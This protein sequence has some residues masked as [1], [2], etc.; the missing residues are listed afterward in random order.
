MRKLLCSLG[1][2][3]LLVWASGTLADEAAATNG[4]SATVQ[5]AASALL[6]PP[7][8]ATK[9]TPAAAQ[10]NTPLPRP[11]AASPTKPAVPPA[12][13]GADK[14]QAA[15]PMDDAMM[16]RLKAQIKSVR[17]S[18]AEATGRLSVTE[19][20][21][22]TTSVDNGRLRAENTSLQTSL[23]RAE[24]ASKK[25]EEEVAVRRQEMRLLEQRGG[26]GTG[27]L[28]VALVLA[29]LVSSVLAVAVFGHGKRLRT[30]VERLPDASGDERRQE[31]LRAQLKDEREKSTKLEEECKRLRD[32]SSRLPPAPAPGSKRDKAEGL[33]RE[34]NDART[35]AE[36]Q[37][38]AAAERVQALEAEIKK[39]TGE[40]QRLDQALSK[41]NEKLVF[42]GHD[43]PEVTTVTAA[44]A[45]MD[46]EPPPS[47]SPGPS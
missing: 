36:E 16:L 28:S 32:V 2:V 5:Q 30:I 15:P 29:L 7:S 12:S 1:T 6:V 8:P 4:K 47:L 17:L 3:A 46:D 21:L 11:E 34:L 43:E 10:A 13:P 40:N 33:R 44:P 39:L 41:A 14:G 23:V 20:D 25:A 26:A 31:Q 27:S 9:S 37:K 18:L 38:R 45:A 24:T 42:L 22:G 19:K 35:A